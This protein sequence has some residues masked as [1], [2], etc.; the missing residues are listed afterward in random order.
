MASDHL[1][2]LKKE[3]GFT[4]KD[5]IDK[6]SNYNVEQKNL[7]DFSF[8]NIQQFNQGLSSVERLKFKGA[9]ISP[10]QGDFRDSTNPF[11]DSDVCMGIFNPFKNDLTTSLG[12]DITK[13]RERMIM[14]KVIKN[15]LSR[16]NVAIGLYCRPETGSFEEL[17]KP[18]EIDYKNY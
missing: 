1:Y 5:N 9:D 4:T 8:I 10:A 18:S 13:L 17:P 2:L 12:Y 6:W 11:A 16:D 3:R 7:F 15:R 14:L